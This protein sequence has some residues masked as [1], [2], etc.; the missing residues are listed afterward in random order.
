MGIDPIE[1]RGSPAYRLWYGVLRRALEIQLSLGGIV[2]DQF[3]SAARSLAQTIDPVRRQSLLIDQDWIESLYAGLKKRNHQS[4]LVTPFISALGF[5][6]FGTEKYGGLSDEDTRDLL[7]LCVAE[8]MFESIKD[9]L[10]EI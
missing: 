1:L 5:D 6:P 9:S 3:K 2:A 10:G 8:L 4:R 7:L